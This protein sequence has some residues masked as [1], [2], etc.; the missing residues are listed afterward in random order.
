MNLL[1]KHWFDLGILFA[2]VVA[3][4]LFY[5]KAN[6]ESLVFIMWLQLIM[7]FLHQFEEYR[8][9]GYFPGLINKVMFKSKI[10]DRFPL[11]SQSALII[12]VL[13][14]W[15]L[16]LLAALFCDKSLWLCNAATLVSFG[17]FM[18]HTSIFNIKG[19]LFYNPG[20][21]TALF[22]FLPASIYFVYYIIENQT[23]SVH[24]YILGDLFGLVP[25]AGVILLIGWL[26]NKNS[27]Y[28]FE[29]RQI[30][31]KDR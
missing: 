6:T 26:K 28:T 10:P 20:M 23:G 22:L 12:N 24:D 19:R 27:S 18:V 21:F 7:L 1:R 4:L 5:F 31:A 29:Q 3:F 30:M 11:N 15:P 8:F 25:N 14:A 17:N 9:P 16:Y 2:A 13:G